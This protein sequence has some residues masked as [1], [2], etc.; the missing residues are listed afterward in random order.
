MEPEMEMD[1]QEQQRMDDQ[2]RMEEM[3]RTLIAYLH[4]MTSNEG[5]LI[6]CRELGIS[7]SD[8]F[9]G[10]IIKNVKRGMDNGQI[11]AN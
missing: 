11:R 10:S 8:E 6:L 4:G 5:F 9:F 7:E 2:Q 1:W 3:E